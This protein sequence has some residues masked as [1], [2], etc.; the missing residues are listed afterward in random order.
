MQTDNHLARSIEQS[1]RKA[2]YDASSKKLLAHKIVLAMI[3]KGCVQEFM[4]YP[5]S[6]IADYYIEGIPQVMTA[7]VH[8]DETNSE[9]IRGLSS[10]DPSTTEGIVKYDIRFSAIVPQNQGH[11]EMIVNIESQQEFDPGYPLLKRAIYYCSRLISSQYGSE[12]THAHYGQI[13]KV[14]SIWICSRP[15]PLHQ[16]TIT[17]YRMREEPLIGHV[18]EDIRHY[19]LLQAIIVG[20][21]DPSSQTTNDTLAFLE[22]LL[23]DKRSPAQKKR[24]LEENFG[25]RMTDEMEKEVET[26]SSLSYGIW[27]EAFEEGQE[28]GELR[29]AQ[30]IAL[31]LY[32]MG[33]SIDQIAKAVNFSEKAVKEWLAE[34]VGVN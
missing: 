25:I 7:G 4:A 23:S 11:M 21:G 10:E 1:G 5:L 15:D 19:D 6:E 22:T 12:F 32:R 29:K 8:K 30:E 27:K 9:Q 26:M 31:N 18:Q 28:Q 34:P 14:Y 33:F 17:R 24:I 2:A 13:K 20:L 16:N 3:L